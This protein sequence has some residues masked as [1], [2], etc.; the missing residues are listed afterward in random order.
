M[1]D[2]S[3]D[4][5]EEK[6]PWKT[7]GPT[8]GESAAVY[9]DPTSRASAVAAASR[10]VCDPR[11]VL[12]ED[13]DV[14]SPES[15]HLE[16][17][18]RSFILQHYLDSTPFEVANLV[19]TLGA[20]ASRDNI[21]NDRVPPCNNY[22]L[23]LA[24]GLVRNASTRIFS[25]R[26]QSIVELI[27]NAL[28]AT[29]ALANENAAGSVGKFGFGAFS[30]FAW[31][32]D[33]PGA[34]L[35]IMSTT[36]TDNAVLSTARVV[37][38]VNVDAQLVV[39]ELS[40][41]FNDLVDNNRQQGTVVDL[42]RTVPMNV[43]Q[44]SEQIARFNYNGLAPGNKQIPIYV[45]LPNKPTQL[46][47]RGTTNGAAGRRVDISL[48]PL[49]V[50]VWDYGSGMSLATILGAF[51][52]PSVS[53]K[54]ENYNNANP[55]A[56]VVP[57]EV[58][59]YPRRKQGGL[60]I[61]VA[62]VTVVT[63]SSKK[64][65]SRI[66]ISFPA[67][68]TVTLARDDLLMSQGTRQI[69][70]DLLVE[71]VMAMVQ[72][73]Q[74]EHKVG[75][76]TAV[77]DFNAL[78]RV[79][80]AWIL[81]TAAKEQ[82]RDLQRRFQ[83]QLDGEITQRNLL[84]LH[85]S[86]LPMIDFLEGQ[87]MDLRN[88]ILFDDLPSD[89][90]E[91]AVADQIETDLKLTV[92]RF[93]ADTVFAIHL[94]DRN[95]PG[96]DPRLGSDRLFFLKHADAGMDENGAKLSVRAI[97]PQLI[98]FDDESNVKHGDGFKRALQY[99]FD[100]EPDSHA[101]AELLKVISSF[102][103]IDT[104]PG[105]GYL[106]ENSLA[107]CRG[108]I[109]IGREL[110]V[111]ASFGLGVLPMLYSSMFGNDRVAAQYLHR[112]V[113]I[114]TNTGSYVPDVLVNA[115]YG[116]DRKPFLP[117][118]QVKWKRIL[119]VENKI[120]IVPQQIE[121]MP[122]SDLALQIAP[123]NV[124]VRRLRFMQGIL[125]RMAM[126]NDQKQAYQQLLTVRWTPEDMAEFLQNRMGM[127]P[128]SSV[129]KRFM[130]SKLSL[131]RDYTCVMVSGSVA[132]N[133]QFSWFVLERLFSGLQSCV[134]LEDPE[135]PFA[136]Q[137]FF[138]RV[139]MRSR[140][141][142]EAVILLAATIRVVGQSYTYNDQTQTTSIPGTEI[143]LRRVQPLELVAIV[144]ALMDTMRLNYTA[145]QMRK[146][147]KKELL[148]N[149]NYD[150]FGLQLNT[151]KKGSWKEHGIWQLTPMTGLW[152][153]QN[154]KDMR[155]FT[156]LTENVHGVL[157]LNTEHRKNTNFPEYKT[158]PRR[159]AKPA[160]GARGGQS[161][162]TLSRLISRVFAEPLDPGLETY[163]AL[164]EEKNSSMW[165]PLP[166]NISSI[167]M[168]E[169]TSKDLLLTLLTETVQNSVDACREL[170]HDK[171]AQPRIEAGLELGSTI[172]FDPQ[173]EEIQGG[174]FDDSADDD[175]GDRHRERP[176]HITRKR[177]REYL[178]VANT[179]ANPT[180][181]IFINI[182][183]HTPQ[184]QIHSHFDQETRP[185]KGTRHVRSTQITNPH[186]RFRLEDPE[187][188]PTEVVRQARLKLSMAPPTAPIN[189]AAHRKGRPSIAERRA[190]FEGKTSTGQKRARGTRPQARRRAPISAMSRKKRGQTRRKI[191]ERTLGKDVLNRVEPAQQDMNDEEEGVEEKSA[192]NS[193][194]GVVL[195][196][197][198]T[199]G[200]PVRVLPYLFLPYL[201]S[202]NPELGITT[203][204][205]GNGLF[206]VYR[207]S[208]LV[209]MI[210]H[211]EDDP[212]EPGMKLTIEDRPLLDPDSR[213]ATDLEKMIRW[214]PQTGVAKHGTS[215]AVFL[216][217]SKGHNFASN[218]VRLTSY[219][220]YH[221]S[222]VQ[223]PSIVLNGGEV[224]NKGLVRTDVVLGV[225]Q[226]ENRRE[227]GEAKSCF[228]VLFLKDH[229]RDSY[230]LTKGIPFRTLESQFDNFKVPKWLHP[231][232][233]FGIIIDVVDPITCYTP[234]QSRA[235]LQLKD[236]AKAELLGTLTDAAYVRA[237]MNAHT[238]A[239]NPIPDLQIGS[240]MLHYQSQQ[241][242]KS[243][244]FDHRKS[245]TA[246]PEDEGT[247][248]RE[249]MPT[250]PLYRFVMFHS[251]WDGYSLLELIT[252]ADKEL[253]GTNIDGHRADYGP[254]L[255]RLKVIKGYFDR[256]KLGK[257]ESLGILP[258]QMM[259]R[260]LATGWLHPKVEQMPDGQPVIQVERRKPQKPGDPILPPPVFV[261]Q[262]R[263]EWEHDQNIK[264]GDL[265]A[266][267]LIQF[268]HKLTS[269]IVSMF[270][271][272]AMSIH[273]EGF[274]RDDHSQVAGG[275]V[276][277]PV[278]EMKS[279]FMARYKGPSRA[280]QQDHIE[281]NLAHFKRRNVQKMALIIIS[282]VS[283]AIKVAQ[284]EQSVGWKKLVGYDSNVGRMEEEDHG[285]NS[286]DR[287]SAAVL[288][289]EL[290][291][292]RQEFVHNSGDHVSVS[293]QGAIYPFD[294][295]ANLVGSQVMQA[296][297]PLVGT[298][299]AECVDEWKEFIETSED[300]CVEEEFAS[301][302]SIEI[303]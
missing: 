72:K 215:V 36:Q 44:F 212:D 99:F 231:H 182:G 300:E 119:N 180:C 265:H 91:K 69:V 16:R 105:D 166:F 129:A 282:D 235:S 39:E 35:T 27:S 206:N 58:K 68:Q 2:N 186:K 229:T 201:S 4:E 221:L 170:A 199:V 191:A 122:D 63:F 123:E 167:A 237:I 84:V 60:V 169:G 15:F 145:K 224:I 112:A 280:L 216:P 228:R 151:V 48:S 9:F 85:S 247:W 8:W 14:R 297:P 196:V 20:Y 222:L 165:P 160:V 126:T 76:D 74:E 92:Y 23:K 77:P 94:D 106:I 5:D 176:T 218:I 295:V 158:P 138:H 143:N 150:M 285:K 104:G 83:E 296:Y 157:R 189:R 223:W 51:L 67:T 153:H 248:A 133:W 31:L 66:R 146:I 227:N 192:A 101:S 22:S 284:L 181:E 283:N 132:R 161:T 245:R 209:R 38:R 238:A 19:C 281:F 279:S 78:V 250:P 7:I 11:Q 18:S 41:N 268:F 120:P 272:T 234:V 136:T 273:I 290:E 233:R 87:S 25:N 113:V 100:L 152:F 162:F 172:N 59:I 109:P 174:V 116:I 210:T 198:D 37:A 183:F 90:A 82:V 263:S 89:E 259:L 294:Y 93:N 253:K 287:V 214:Q 137:L 62:G 108:K 275:G 269:R 246:F 303:F 211:R 140:N 240:F 236:V 251:Y 301:R 208:Q 47:N 244:G 171:G 261:E 125:G 288:L 205:M 168:N 264:E 70:A 163:Q 141:A 3:D 49:R 61:I 102:L 298:M 80:D 40:D 17:Q 271:K 64:L 96:Y 270:V 177:H 57:D 50:S 232:L 98:M 128:R 54:M 117:E 46:I 267:T 33:D 252:L 219:V 226:R 30:H 217:S 278:I 213:K 260:D 184:G 26:Y 277:A 79:L 302:E 225:H 276:V 118:L 1:H 52:V 249:I 241:D 149:Q 127:A 28:D 131:L 193:I 257:D 86:H 299:I 42:T 148:F 75:D 242:R 144:D 111:V 45:K 200:I 155:R 43:N 239:F 274:E 34:R 190:A 266:I 95:L 10:L 292:G 121:E 71:K 130:E 203:G 21:E 230:V 114:A 286:K 291:H 220:K 154:L 110:A 139:L 197:V 262:Q 175:G 97:N 29:P 289:H 107:F 194:A 55:E 32:Y 178:G 204:E 202:K 254:P 147:M 103:S 258:F 156:D 124:N 195:E 255:E 24:R 81:R 12:A 179:R 173:I 207:D 88:Y 134:F 135:A 142:T 187:P 13:A 185:D 164:A 6:D 73:R 115:V 188:S 56:T 293:F 53:T 159:S 256:V 243:V 65:N